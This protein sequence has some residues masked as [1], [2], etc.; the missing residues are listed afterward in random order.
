MSISIQEPREEQIRRRAHEIWLERVAQNQ[1]GDA[2]S[3]WH[4]AELELGVPPSDIDP[5]AS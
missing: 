2:E 1:P 4:R 3:D 5:A